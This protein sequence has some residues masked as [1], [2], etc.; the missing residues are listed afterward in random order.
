VGTARLSRNVSRNVENANVAQR[1]SFLES[2][3]RH[4]WD[5]EVFR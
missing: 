1:N 4:I 2:G 5:F 3:E